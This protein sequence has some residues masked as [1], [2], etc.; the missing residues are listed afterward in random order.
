MI[1]LS[2]CNSY[3][4]IFFLKKIYFVNFTIV[5]YCINIAACLLCGA[6]KP[7]RVSVKVKKHQHVKQPSEKIRKHILDS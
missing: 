2:F 4:L 1:L 5:F 6:F 3:K 7:F